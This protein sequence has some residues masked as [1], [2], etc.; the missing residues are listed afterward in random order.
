MMRI[1]QVIGIMAFLLSIGCAGQQAGDDGF[2]ANVCNNVPV[3][4]EALAAADPE[5]KAF[6]ISCADLERCTDVMGWDAP[7]DVPCTGE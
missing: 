4:I 1:Y 3:G 7:P 6:K 2:D 5:D